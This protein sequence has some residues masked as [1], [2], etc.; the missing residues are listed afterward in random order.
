MEDTIHVT[1]PGFDVSL[2]AS[3]NSSEDLNDWA[4]IRVQT[5]V[6]RRAA[7]RLADRLR[8]AAAETAPGNDVAAVASRPSTGSYA[9]LK[10]ALGGMRKSASWG[11][12]ALLVTFVAVCAMLYPSK[13]SI[14]DGISGEV[15]ATILSVPVH[16]SMKQFDVADDPTATCEQLQRESSSCT[17]QP[18]VFETFNIMF[19]GQSGLGKSTCQANIFRHLDPTWQHQAM[20]DIE[21]RREQA[22]Q[23][24][25]RLERLGDDES[26]FVNQKSDDERAAELFRERK[27]ETAVLNTAIKALHEAQAEYGRQEQEMEELERSI[28]DVEAKQK[29]LRNVSK[30]D[31]SKALQA[32][33]E[34]LRA[35]R[36]QKMM[37]WSMTPVEAGAPEQTLEVQVKEV[38]GMPLWRNSEQ[39]LDVKLIDTPGFSDVVVGTEGSFKAVL[40][41]V[42]AR[43]Q[44]HAAECAHNVRNCKDRSGLVHVCVF[45]LGPHRMMEDDLRM[46][47]RLHTVCPLIPVIAKSDTMTVE[48]SVDYKDVVRRTMR[49]RNISTAELDGRA[50]RAIETRH[51]EEHG[52][53]PHYRL[54][55]AVMASHAADEHGEAQ[56]GYPWGA[57]RPDH[58]PHSELPALREMLLQATPPRSTDR[59]HQQISLSPQPRPVLGSPQPFTSVSPVPCCRRVSGACCATRP[60]TALTLR[61]RDVR[62]VRGKK[63]SAR[64]RRTPKRR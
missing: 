10:S 6:R 27:E 55:L 24:C 45:F 34:A 26:F 14:V 41:E 9:Q 35:T 47:E 39:R 46:M 8:L 52:F 29:A 21:T 18:S 36:Q 43:L 57:A 62:A 28:E 16:P 42:E 3:L 63:S 5:I 13:A 15:N 38:R 20:R 58:P 44:R 60:W 30:Y 33:L 25:E 40:D 51:A 23:I 32:S 4:A 64:S 12:P 48:E 19:V 1:W 11:V 56:R 7:R 31:D 54:P 53:K 59:P 50:W 37:R 17:T 2:S 22:M 61:W 49:M